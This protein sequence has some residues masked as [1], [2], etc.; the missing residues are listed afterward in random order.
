MEMVDIAT[1]IFPKA[2]VPT[3]RITKYAINRPPA[4]DIILLKASID[5]GK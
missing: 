3:N 5:I 1:N 2:S 4:A